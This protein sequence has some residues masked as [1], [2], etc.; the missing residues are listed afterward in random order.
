[1][2]ES[3][4]PK[5]GDVEHSGGDSPSKKQKGGV[6]PPSNKPAESSLPANSGGKGKGRGKGANKGRGHPRSQDSGDAHQLVNAMARLLLRHDEQLT[7]LTSE[8]T[9]VSYAKT[10]GH[11]VLPIL[12]AENRRLKSERSLIPPRQALTMRFFRELK[13]R[14]IAISKDRKVQERLISEGTL[15]SEGEWPFHEWSVGDQALAETLE[16]PLNTSQV[17]SG[18]GDIL[19]RLSTDNEHVKMFRTSRP[20]AE[21]M[22]GGPVRIQIQ[23]STRPATADLVDS[24]QSLVGSSA[25]SLLNCDFQRQGLQMS[26][27]V[28]QVRDLMK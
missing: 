21:I 22:T 24:L 3:L 15:N 6:S 27:L 1:M 20:L 4:A 16:E 2:D 23:F 17:V 28:R 8:V 10:E 14:L 25:F 12:F 13:E 7:A 26:P 5:R 19:A 9:F 11:S 18:V